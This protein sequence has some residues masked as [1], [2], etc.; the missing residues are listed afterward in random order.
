MRSTI[1][2]IVTEHAHDRL[3]DVTRFRLR[4]A[5]EWTRRSAYFSSAG[6]IAEKMFGCARSR[7]AFLSGFCE[8]R[9]AA[10]C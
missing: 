6:R 1:E 4:R 8:K 5:S 3:N 7:V 2:L 10:R 9:D